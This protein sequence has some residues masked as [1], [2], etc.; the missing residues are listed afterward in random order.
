[1]GGSGVVWFWRRRPGPV[2][3]G[4]LGINPGYR[5]FSSTNWSR[6]AIE[7]VSMAWTLS[8]LHYGSSTILPGPGDDV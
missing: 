5:M 6:G 4:G 1:M 2:I 3:M 7:E 8:H